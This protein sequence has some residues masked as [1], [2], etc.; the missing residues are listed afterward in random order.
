MGKKTKKDEITD[1]MVVSDESVMPVPPVDEA[2]LQ[3]NV[4]IEMWEGPEKDERQLPTNEFLVDDP[5]DY[6][7]GSPNPRFA[8]Y[9]KRQVEVDEATKPLHLRTK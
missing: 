3:A 4:P 2:T 1:E 7:N 5:T 8:A 6:S 9:M